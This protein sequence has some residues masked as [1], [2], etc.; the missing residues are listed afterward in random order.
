M[1]C[2]DDGAIQPQEVGHARAYLAS[3]CNTALLAHDLARQFH[4]GFEIGACGDA[5]PGESVM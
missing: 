4:L 1:H 5:Q 2:N 3:S